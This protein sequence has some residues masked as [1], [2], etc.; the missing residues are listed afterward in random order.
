MQKNQPETATVPISQASVLAYVEPAQP[1]AAASKTKKLGTNINTPYSDYAPF[2]YGERLYFSTTKLDENGNPSIDHIVSSL[3]TGTPA[4]WTENSEKQGESTA[5]AA[6]TADN[7]RIY[8][9]IC[10]EEKPGKQ[11]CEILTRERA[12]EGYWLPAKRL[13]GINM[14]GFNSTHPSIGFDF[15]LR[16]EV[17]YFASDRPGGKG[18]YDVWCS[19]IEANGVH[20]TPFP[21]P[22]NSP[23]DD[24]TPFFYQQG[25]VLF[26][27][28]NRQEKNGYDIYRIEKKNKAWG[29]A[30]A[31]NEVFNSPY[32][33]VYF[34]CHQRSGRTYF[35]SD[36]PGCNSADPA[37]PCIGYDIYEGPLPI[38]LELE[39]LLANGNAL[40]QD[41]SVSIVDSET[42]IALTPETD[43]KRHFML[44]PGKKYRATVE[45]SA[46]PRKLWTLRRQ[47]PISYLLSKNKSG[48]T[49]TQNSSSIPT[50][51]WTACH[52]GGRSLFIR[53]IKL[54]RLP[55]K[56]PNR[57]IPLALWCHL[58]II[59][60]W[61]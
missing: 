12:F 23:Q 42:G 40:L 24:V 17:L 18:G 35:C 44:E 54:A 48:C 31:L 61:K 4:D 53:A 15:N 32:N 49:K 11:E 33:E 38:E 41:A 14:D 7:R 57:T 50:T 59:P 39:V 45:A 2:R 21:L 51:H 55:I 43:S 37:K 22:F 3:L 10:K 25:Q 6:L 29:E 13:K 8:Y 9:T 27:S 34:T 52:W 60:S 26:F 5:H 47:P 36:R 56:M 16:K 1:D 30:E 46:I 20:G 58:A 19:P 28:S